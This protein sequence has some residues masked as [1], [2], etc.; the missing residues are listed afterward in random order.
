MKDFPKVVIILFF[1][2]GCSGT[3]NLSLQVLTPGNISV[4]KNIHVM[5]IVNRS[6]PQNKLANTIEGILTGES[7]NEDKQDRQEMISGLNASLLQ[8]PLFKVSMSAEN[9]IGSGTGNIFPEPLKWAAVERICKDQAADALVAL[10]TF[11]SDCIT[12]TGSN[13]VEKTGQNGEKIK[14]KEFY[15]DQTVYIKFGFRIYNSTNRNIEDQFTD[16]YTRKWHTKGITIQDALNSLIAKRAAM[17]Q[18]SFQAGED[19]GRRISPNWITVYRRYYKKGNDQMKVAARKVSV[20]SWD[21]AAKLWQEQ[22]NEQNIKIRGRAAYNMAL[23]HEVNGNL[24]EAKEWADKAYSDYNNKKARQ[25][26]YLLGC[27]IR[28]QQKLDQQM[29]ANSDSN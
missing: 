17:A 16:T 20:N 25:Y 10:E 22:M 2:S 26:S 5:T 13:L 12:S 9:L 4:S 8:S 28:E 7:L 1:L 18:T 29:D 15:A 24:R 3:S 19:Y 21:A 11:D 6:Q 27:R 14:V 23:F